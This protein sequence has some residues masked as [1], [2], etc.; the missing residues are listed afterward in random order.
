MPHRKHEVVGS[1]VGRLIQERIE[2]LYAKCQVE[3]PFEQLKASDIKS[4]QGDVLMPDEQIM[5]LDAEQPALV[6]EVGNSQTA[7]DLERKARRLVMAGKGEIR[8]VVTVKFHRGSRVDLTVWRPRVIDGSLTPERVDQVIRDT[9]AEPVPGAQ[10]GIPMAE[11][12]PPELL[13]DSLRNEIIII[14][15][16]EICKVIKRAEAYHNSVGKNR[17]GVLPKDAECPSSPA[18]SVSSGPSDD[19]EQQQESMPEDEYKPARRMRP[20][21]PYRSPIKA[22]ARKVNKQ[23]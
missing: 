9:N 17:F 15:S 18:N 14:T 4:D 22:R 11:M 12:A 5:C 3:C 8:Q 10:L 20:G 13:H 2:Q 6:V 23:D 7:E 16:E 21:E 19:E 1:R